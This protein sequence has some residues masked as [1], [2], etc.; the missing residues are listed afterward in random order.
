MADFINYAEI[1]AA[2]ETIQVRIPE[3]PEIGI[4]QGLGLSGLANSIENLWSFR[5]MKGPAGQFP[6]L[7]AMKASWSSVGWMARQ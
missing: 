7:Q 2:S 4:I 3:L 5:R 6:L 1:D